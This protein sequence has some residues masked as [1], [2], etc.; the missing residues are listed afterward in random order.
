VPADTV[1][2]ER[3]RFVVCGE[4]SLAVRLAEELVSRYAGEVCVIV[5]SAAGAGRLAALERVEVVIADRPD[6]AAFAAAGLPDADG[7]ALVDQDD[8]GNI[9]AALSAREVNPAVRLVIRAFNLSLGERVAALLGNCAVLSES[10]IAAP[11]FVTAALGPQDRRLIVL[12]G[13]DLYLAR[14]DEVAPG[15]VACGVAVAGDAGAPELLPADEDRADLVLAVSRVERPVPATPRRLRHPLRTLTLLLGA[16]LR[17][18]LAALLGVLVLGSL[19]LLVANRGLGWWLSVYLVVL[20][21]LGAG[22]PEYD[23]PVAEQALQLLLALVSAALIPLITAAVV[24]AL[25]NARLRLAAG[26][27]SEPVSGHVVVVGLGNVGTRVLQ[28]LHERGVPTVGIDPSDQARGVTVARQLG[29]PVVFGDATHAET[30]AA[31]CVGS[32][33]AVVVASGSDVNTLETALLSR[34]VNPDVR[35]VLRLF[36]GEFAARIQRVVRGSSSH[37]V[38]YL[39][40][41][42]FAAALIGQQVVDV[43]PVRRRVLLV[44]EVGVVTD[45]AADGRPVGSLDRAHQVRLLGIRTGRGRQVIWRPPPARPLQRTDR[46][47]A[48]CTRAGLGW[49]LAEV[50]EPATTRSATGDG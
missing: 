35:L 19:A 36:D 40:A 13:R 12:P 27:L 47:I 38:S 9:D 28:A 25:V 16:R 6:A 20:S 43:V 15:D 18:V 26:G 44:C 17:L 37:S 22:N 46:L 8:G 41:P 1:D 48:V 3:R 4:T 24:E 29:I 2:D 10:A 50:G 23:A 42:A 39:A 33:A 34:S 32:A 30:L 11:A 14:R 31:A 7:L 49:L 21:T 5:G 45:S